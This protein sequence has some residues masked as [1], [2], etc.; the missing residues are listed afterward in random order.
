MRFYVKKNLN[1]NQAYIFP[2]GSDELGSKAMKIV[3]EIHPKDMSSVCESDQEAIS[4]GN[5]DEFVIIPFLFAFQCGQTKGNSGSLDWS[6][7]Y[8]P[9]TT[10]NDTVPLMR[11]FCIICGF[12]SGIISLEKLPKCPGRRPKEINIPTTSEDSWKCP[13][14]FSL[15]G[16]A[17]IRLRREEMC[18]ENAGRTPVSKDP[19]AIL[20]RKSSCMSATAA[21]IHTRLIEEI[22]CR[23]LPVPYIGN[24]FRKIQLD[25]RTGLF[26]GVR[27]GIH[28]KTTMK[29]A[30]KLTCRVNY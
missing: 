29:F 20:W 1:R 30:I 27:K 5:F 21:I 4:S 22:G 28:I 23:Y 8:L 10:L 15:K 11:A 26:T 19:Y 18:C 3:W 7:I 2:C 6:S 13:T 16:S 24:R 17:E 9:W 14:W 25:R 12:Q